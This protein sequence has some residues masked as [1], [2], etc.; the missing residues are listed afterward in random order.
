MPRQPPD[1]FAARTAETTLNGSSLTIAQQCT[2]YTHPPLPFPS[3]YRQPTEPA[4]DITR[5]SST[6]FSLYLQRI[7][8]NYQQSPPLRDIATKCVASNFVILDFASWKCSK[9]GKPRV[10]RH[11]RVESTS[12]LTVKRQG[13]ISNCS[14][15]ERKLSAER[16]KE[17]CTR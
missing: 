13:C 17:V 12:K 6:N 3:F 14:R 16:C 4:E 5:F 7:Y 11:L 9:I 15:H 2:V 8:E 1:G 10:G